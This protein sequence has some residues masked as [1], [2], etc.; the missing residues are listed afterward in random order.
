[1]ANSRDGL[2]KFEAEKEFTATGYIGATPTEP[3]YVGAENQL[4]IALENVGGSNEVECY[5]RIRNQVD[6][7]LLT[8][9][10]GSTLGFTIDISLVDEI[11]FES[12]VYAASG[13][14]PRLVASGFFKKAT[15]DATTASNLGAGEGVFS[16]K[17]GDDLQFKSL[18]AGSGISLS[19]TSSEITIAANA[20]PRLSVVF[21]TDLSTAVGDLMYITG[22]NFVS[23]IPDNLTTTIPNGIFG[24]AFNKP[25]TTTVEVVFVGIIPGYSGFTLGDALY[26]STGGI[27]THVPPSSGV[28]QQIGFAVSA[29]ELF[30]YLQQPIHLS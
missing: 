23:T 1:M 20:S 4:R 9:V 13:G 6:F 17:A 14:T 15:S 12:T 7:T 5:G 30:L 21:D 3:Y 24:V 8:T 27:P 26:I 18:V 16:S 19:S 25:T 29:T 10:T 2:N 22:T 11:Y 28:L